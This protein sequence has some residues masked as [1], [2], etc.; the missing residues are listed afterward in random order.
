MDIHPKLIFTEP[1]ERNG[2][3]WT[4]ASQ[5][6]NMLRLAEQR[7]GPRDRSYTFV[8]IEFVNGVPQIWFPGNCQHVAI[9]LGLPC[10]NEPDRACFQ[11]AHETIHLL[12]PT[13]SNDPNV[14]EEGLA[15]HFQSW[16]MKN[17][18]PPD[19]PMSCVDWNTLACKSYEKAR[20]LV[21]E[22]LKFGDDIIKKLRV[23][24]PTLSRIT[25]K[26]I[27][28]CVPAVL[29]PSKDGPTPHRNEDPLIGF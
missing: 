23:A 16:Y 5:L 3:T 12:S 17:H 6:G 8:G 25:A 11:L 9:Q 10:M 19:W 20:A 13:G 27:Q 2:Y 15:A 22:L 26:L 21:H 1:L 24:E 28:E 4:L 7:F 14:L 29:S 18:Y